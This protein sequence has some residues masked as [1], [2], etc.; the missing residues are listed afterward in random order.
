MGFPYALSSPPPR[1]VTIRLIL[2]HR[3]VQGWQHQYNAMGW[4]WWH[5]GLSWGLSP[6]PWHPRLTLKTAARL[7]HGSWDHLPLVKAYHW[8]QKHGNQEATIEIFVYKGARWTRYGFALDVFCRDT[9]DR[10]S[11]FATGRWISQNDTPSPTPHDALREAVAYLEKNYPN[12]P[13]CLEWA[14][15]LLAPK[16]L[17]LF[18]LPE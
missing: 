16:Q 11:G 1:P 10:P 3:L 4:P 7:A 13:Q 5:G 12:S 9:Y 15:G 14:R 2:K 6:V 17:C 8:K 18:S